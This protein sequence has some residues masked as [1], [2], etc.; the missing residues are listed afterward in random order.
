MNK[1][2]QAIARH[3]RARKKVDALS[4]RI[5]A[6]IDRCPVMIKAN[7]YILSNSERAELWD[8]K[9]QRHKTHL[10]QA[11]NETTTSECGCGMRLL[12]QDEQEEWLCQRNGGCRHCLRAWRLIRDR[13]IAKRELG[14]ARLSLRALGRQAIK[15]IGDD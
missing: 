12:D 15:E 6:A 1:Y 7:D 9:T 3:E 2:M 8:E 5:G 14:Y 4:R 13:S 11:Y 10:W